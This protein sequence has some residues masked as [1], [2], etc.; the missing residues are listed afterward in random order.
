MSE[1]SLVVFDLAG[2]T[3][4]D[5]DV[6]ADCL[7][8]ALASVG[9]SATT[10]DANAV[11]GMPKPVAIAR[12]IE[13]AESAPQ[14][15][16]APRVLAATRVFED[17]IRRH[18]GAP[19]GIVPIPGIED[20]FAD[21]HDAA[22]CIAIDTGFS[23]R[24]TDDILDRLGWIARGAVDLRVTSDEVPRGRPAP[25]MIFEAM[26]RL[27][28][29]DPRTVAKVGDTPADLREGTAAGCRWVIGVTYGSHRRGELVDHP[30]TAIVDDARELLAALGVSRAR[31]AVAERRAS[32]SVSSR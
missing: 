4:E 18:Y 15:I 24:V 27:A 26:R 9:V 30:H 12:L 11:M 32:P 6:V 3:I 2:T 25:D 31:G 16:D 22:V 5:H 13:R 10:E 23:A 14:A 1:L 17:A 29:I 21:L 19:G 8:S 28:I 7:V 20:V